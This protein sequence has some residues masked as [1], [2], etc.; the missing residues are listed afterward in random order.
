MT[1]MKQVLFVTA[2]GLLIMV[3]GL[4]AA[5]QQNHL[6]INAVSFNYISGTPDYTQSKGLVAGGGSIP[7]D[8]IANVALP[9]GAV[10][11]A[12]RVCG[13][14][15]ASDQNFVANLWRKT[16]NKANSAFTPPELMATLQTDVASGSDPMQ[17]LKTTKITAK[18]IDNTKWTYFIELQIG[19]TIEVISATIDY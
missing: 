15:D 9:Q 18:T 5:A 6:T 12:F 1:R 19:E 14:D 8:G 16:I 2:L 7:A 10:V 11:A 13:R 3:C 17:C 4:Q